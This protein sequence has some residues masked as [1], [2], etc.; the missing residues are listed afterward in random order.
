M[1]GPSEGL[2]ATALN[3]QSDYGRRRN[4]IPRNDDTIVCLECDVGVHGRTLR[5]DQRRMTR[6]RS[7]P[8]GGTFQ[9]RHYV[10]SPSF[11]SRWMHSGR[12]CCRHDLGLGQGQRPPIAIED[13]GN[14]VSNRHG[15]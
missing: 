2:F 11:R 7:S 3:A 6:E 13:S 14:D 10:A 8:G 15:H 9:Y 5:L 1:H 12:R 4:A